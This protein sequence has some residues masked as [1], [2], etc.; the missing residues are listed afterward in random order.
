MEE[1]KA[2]KP[3]PKTILVIPSKPEYE[4]KPLNT[5]T[6]LLKSMPLINI[7]DSLIIAEKMLKNER[8][9]EALTQYEQ[10]FSRL[11]SD[12]KPED[13]ET[14]FSEIFLKIALLAIN[15]LN[16]SKKDLCF[17]LLTRCEKT[18]NEGLFGNFPQL[19]CLVFNHMGCYYRRIGKTDLALNYYEKALDLL[20]EHDRKK[21]SGLTHMNLSAIYSQTEK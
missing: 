15:F 21:Y 9:L 3:K 7:D 2:I 17:S 16:T 5:K 18:L 11:K 6:T 19:K 12:L 8:I 13:F 14:R 4:R 10:I 1:S 20:K